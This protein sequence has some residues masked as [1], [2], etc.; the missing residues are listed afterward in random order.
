MVTRSLWCYSISTS[1]PAFGVC[2]SHGQLPVMTVRCLRLRAAARAVQRAAGGEGGRAAAGG[3]VRAAGPSAGRVAAADA[4]HPRARHRDRQGPQVPRR[5]SPGARHRD[6]GA[7]SRHGCDD[8]SATSR[9]RQPSSPAACKRRAMTILSPTQASPAA[10]LRVQLTRMDNSSALSEAAAQ[11]HT[12]SNFVS[13]CLG[14]DASARVPADQVALAVGD[15]GRGGARAAHLGAAAGGGLPEGPALGLRRPHRRPR[16]VRFDAVTAVRIG[17][18]VA[19][20]QRDD[21]WPLLV[22][23]LKICQR[24]QLLCNM[25]LHS[26]GRSRA[27]GR[28]LWYF[29]CPSL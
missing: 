29:C 19:T 2:M 20:Q 7:R 13:R 26:A 9:G 3:G 5:P 4:E 11:A 24:C 21:M 18:L 16:E 12:V 28:H 1:S 15:G 22:T 27:L 14:H 17:T 23:K 8:H 25:L 6:A 10:Y